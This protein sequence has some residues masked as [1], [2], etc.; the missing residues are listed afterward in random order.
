M[1][2]DPSIA[3][4]LA[5]LSMPDLALYLSSGCPN[6]FAPTEPE[7]FYTSDPGKALITMQCSD[8]NRLKGPA[9]RRLAAR[10]PYFHNGAAADLCGAVNF[11]NERFS[12][13]LNGDQK[14]ALVAFLNSL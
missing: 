11:Y 3:P 9:R 1:D 13:Q 8:F 2:S 6:P 7:S 5:Q 12:M 4:A 10:T 14:S